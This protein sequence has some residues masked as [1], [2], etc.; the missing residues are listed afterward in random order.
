MAL[1]LVAV[2]GRTGRRHG[3]RGDAGTRA[4]GG[5]AGRAL[6]VAIALGVR[7]VSLA[8]LLFTLLDTTLIV[9]F[10]AIAGGAIPTPYAFAAVATGLIVWVAHADNI[11]RLLDG[12]ERR[13]DLAVLRGGPAPPEA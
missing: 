5:A 6:F 10:W 11:Q 4:S 9:G 1:N 3:C 13:M 8:T 2:R 12:T 7:Y